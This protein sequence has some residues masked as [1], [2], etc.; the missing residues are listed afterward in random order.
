[1]KYVVSFSGGVSSWAAA[2]RLRE[3]VPAEDMTLLFAD[4]KIEDEDAYRFL[5]QAASNVGVPLTVLTEGRTPWQVFRDERFIANTRVDLCSR[6]LKREPLQAWMDTHAPEAVSVLGF[7]AEEANRLD[8]YRARMAPR[9][10]AAPLC[11]APT[12]DKDDVLDW[13][14]REG[15]TIPRLYRLGFKTNNC[16]GFC[17][18]AGIEQF[19]LLHRTLPDRY[20]AHEAQEES[21]RE[22]LGNVSIMRDRRHGAVTPLPMRELR[23]RI[24]QQETFDGFGG[25]DCACFDPT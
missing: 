9:P 3:T 5:V 1:M 16:G 23:R 11:E 4:T 2:K 25:Q 15:L 19:A 20:K 12:L 7:T 14:K 8:R 6:I 21:M 18:K 22:T 10:V 24:E 13:A 17:V